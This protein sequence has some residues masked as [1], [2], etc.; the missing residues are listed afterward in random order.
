MNQYRYRYARDSASDKDDQA[1]RPGTGRHARSSG[2]LPGAFP[3]SPPDRSAER[4]YAAVGAI[5]EAQARF[6]GTG[7]DS[8][9]I[10]TAFAAARDIL[11]E[12][13]E[14]L[15]EARREAR[16]ELAMARSD[17]EEPDNGRRAPDTA[18]SVVPDAPGLDLCPDPGTA[19]TPAQYM[20]TL[21]NYR[22]WAGQPSYRTMGQQCG[23]RFAA[24]TIHAALSSNELPTLP[25]VQAVITSCGGTDA[26]QQMFATAWRRL[27]MLRPEPARAS[28]SRALDPAGGTDQ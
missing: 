26:H 11:N 4:I 16:R 15:R 14:L 2:P 19:R 17:R 25:M 23:Q 27:R 21:R 28:R 10:N 3:D 5:G 20:D 24:S 7:V 9:A 6:R 18:V 12:A 8:E 22:I 1:L 13:W